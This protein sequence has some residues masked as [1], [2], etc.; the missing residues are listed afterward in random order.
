MTPGS[1]RCSEALISGSGVILNRQKYEFGRRHLTF[2]GHTTNGNGVS[3]DPQKTNA[4]LMMVKPK[5][6]TELRRFL[7]MV[8]KLSKFTPNIASLT[9]PL[10]EF[11]ST[12]IMVLEPFPR[13]GF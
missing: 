11:L 8:N 13:P 7:G 1:T 2:L 6:P 9:K 5:T 4:I 10:Q 12:K 3:P